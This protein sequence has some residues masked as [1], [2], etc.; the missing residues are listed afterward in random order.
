ML[1]KKGTSGNP[2]G[3]PKAYSGDYGLHE[4]WWGDWLSFLKTRLFWSVNDLLTAD[5]TKK[6][7]DNSNLF[8]IKKLKIKLS[9]HSIENIT[10]EMMKI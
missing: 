6:Y 8:F 5:L 7:F 4:L 1:F 9:K 10:S 3:R 2:I